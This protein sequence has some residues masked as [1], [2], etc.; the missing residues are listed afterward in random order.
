MESLASPS[1]PVVTSRARAACLGLVAVAYAVVY[2]RSLSWPW[3]GLDDWRFIV[4]NPHLGHGW[5][6]AWWGLTD[7][8]FGRRWT[9]VAWLVACLCG[10][11]TAL[12]FHV[13]VFVLGLILCLLV[14]EI[15]LRHLDPR[16]A[17]VAALLFA[18]SPLRI[19]VFAWSMGFVY[20]T[21]AIFLCAAWLARARP[22]VSALLVVAALAAYPQA[23]GAAVG[24]VILNRRRPAGWLVA[25]ALAAM[26]LLQYSLRVHIGLVAWNPRVDYLPLILPHYALNLLV[27]FA[28]VPLFPSLPYGLMI[29]GAAAIMVAAAARPA[30]VGWWILLFLPTLAASVTEAFWFGARYCLIPSIFAYIILAREL[31]TVRSKVVL[32]LAW[33][34]VAGFAFLNIEDNGM[35]RG[36][37]LC[38]RTATQEAA[39]VGIDFDLVRTLK[40]QPQTSRP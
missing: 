33:A 23:A 6:S 38:A 36:V 35:S 5:Q 40:D 13:L 11:P 16:W 34:L 25:A 30:A 19:E 7:V 21:A 8:E 10:Q 3:L 32:P 27:P 14:A 18:L 31:S 9:P 26:A 1:T 22:W 4:T 29:A 20:A 17:P 15:C 2:A 12:G 37:G 28:T 39:L 24:F